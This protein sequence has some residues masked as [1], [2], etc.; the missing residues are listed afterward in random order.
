[1]YIVL[2]ICPVVSAYNTYFVSYFNGE[3][4][5]RI[6]KNKLLGLSDIRYVLIIIKLVITQ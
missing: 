2:R 6:S 1:M 3:Y 5:I 4:Y